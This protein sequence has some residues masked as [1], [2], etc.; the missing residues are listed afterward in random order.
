MI[1]FCFVIKIISL[2]AF[3]TMAACLLSSSD[4]ILI[5][6]GSV[7]FLFGLKSNF[8]EADTFQLKHYYI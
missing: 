8:I 4:G 7:L 3:T 6:S 2:S 5:T 1:F